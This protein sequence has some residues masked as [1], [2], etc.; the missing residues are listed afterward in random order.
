VLPIGRPVTYPVTYNAN[1]ATSG[2]APA[3]QTKTQGVALTLA[4]NS[5]NLARTGYAFTGWNT[6]ANGS[7][8]TYTAGDSYTANAAVTLYAKWTE[9]YPVTYNA[10]GA[11]IGS[12]PAS[13][14]KI[15]DVALTLASNSG[16][17][18]RTGYAFSGWNTA[19][20]GSGTT[21]AAGA[22]YTANAA[23]TLYAKWQEAAKVPVYRFWSDSLKSHF[24]TISEAEKYNVTANVSDVWA[25][26][27]IAFYVHWL[28]VDG[29][30]PVHR[31]WSDRIGCH[32]FT[33]S[34]EEKATLQARYA[35]VFTYEGAA[36]H[37]F[38][39]K[40]PGT[41]PVY[42]FWDPKLK[43]PF[44]TIS[45]AEKNSI[46][47]NSSAT[48]SYQGIAWYAY[49]SAS[50]NAPANIIPQSKA[51]T[52]SISSSFIAEAGQAAEL[53][54]AV[55]FGLSYGA[56]DVVSAMVHDPAANTF[57]QVL[58]PTLSPRELVIPPLPFGQRYWLSV[59][60]RRTGEEN[61][62]IDY[63]GWL[64]RVADVPR[65]AVETVDAVDD[66]PIGLPMENIE[67][68]ESSGPLTLRLYE[69]TGKRL[70]ET[71]S[72]LEGGSTYDLAVPAWNQWYRV[73]IVNESSET[74]ISDLCIGHLRTH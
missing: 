27:G 53:P 22:S 8:T 51:S 73:D 64:G 57:T 28:A 25:Y 68:P 60:S 30:L 23:V 21:Y 72:G 19:A 67:L 1:G 10:N 47:A 32:M 44:Y 20:N 63:G 66:M 26:E 56:E 62:S 45:E 41:L 34:D 70:V 58:E 74:V 11:A 13:Q 46:S 4:S 40:A 61:E 14:T 38:N 6:A 71:I 37:A 9:A 7:G 39:Y 5:G 24:F 69:Q 65:E 35:K 16:N 33:I 48:W 17:L 50:A 54:G 52:E 18:A 12:A 43:K 3:S 36:W 15:K 31:F 2:S 29:S 42:R 55:T 49:T 59:M